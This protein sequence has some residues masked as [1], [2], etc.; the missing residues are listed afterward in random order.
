[1]R[2]GGLGAAQALVA[3]IDWNPDPFTRELLL[4]EPQGEEVLI[5]RPY[6]TVLRALVAGQ[7]PPVVFVHGYTTVAE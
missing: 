7:G 4:A 2:V 5:P 3:R 6:G 1:M